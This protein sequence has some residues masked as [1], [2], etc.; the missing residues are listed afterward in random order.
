[1]GH[2][3]NNPTPG[4]NNVTDTS[5]LAT[6][7]TTNHRGKRCPRLSQGQR[8]H[9]YPVSLSPLVARQIRWAVAEKFQH[10]YLPMPSS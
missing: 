1:L 3:D 6:D 5:D 9:T 7:A 2:Y 8:R 10:L 4:H